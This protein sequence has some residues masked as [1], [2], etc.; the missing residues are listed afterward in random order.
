LSISVGGVTVLEPRRLDGNNTA[1]NAVIFNLGGEVVITMTANAQAN[2]SFIRSITLFSGE[3]VF[4]RSIL[5]AYTLESPPVQ[6]KN[7]F[8]SR[9][10]SFSL[11]G[12]GPAEP[13]SGG[14]GVP[15]AVADSQEQELI[16]ATTFGDTYEDIVQIGVA[17]S[18]QDGSST[19]CVS[20]DGVSIAD[21]HPLTDADEYH[22]FPVNNLIGDVVITIKST[23][24][25]THAFIKSVTLYDEIIIIGGPKSNYHTHTWRCNHAGTSEDRAYVAAAIDND[26]TILGFTD[27]LMQPWV[28]YET[29]TWGSFRF[30][31]DY[32]SSIRALQTEFDGEIDILL[33]FEAE[34]DVIFYP[35]FRWLL[36][37]NLVDYLILGQHEWLFDN[38]FDRYV[39]FPHQLNS[40]EFAEAFVDHSIQAMETGLFSIMAHPDY[41]LS[42]F[43]EWS[44]DLALIVRRLCEAALR[45]NVA[46]E[47][48]Q[49]TFNSSTQGVPGRRRV[50]PEFWDIAADVG[51]TV[52]IGIDAHAPSEF[53]E[54]H[55]SNVIDFAR[56]RGVRGRRLNIVEDL[57]IQRR[58]PNPDPPAFV[59][60]GREP[61]PMRTPLLLS[62]L[63]SSV[64]AQ[65]TTNTQ[66]DSLMVVSQ[67]APGSGGGVRF[68]NTAGSFPVSTHMFPAPV[69]V[70][71]NDFIHFDIDTHRAAANIMFLI[72]PPSGGSDLVAV[73]NPQIKSDGAL[74]VQTG[75][76]RPNAHMKG[77]FMVR[78]MSTG[79][80][81][82][83]SEG[84][85]TPNIPVSQHADAEGFITIRGLRVS[86]VNGSDPCLPCRM[87]RA[88]FCGLLGGTEADITNSYV[89]IKQLAFEA[90]T[91]DRG[92]V[93]VTGI[94]I[95]GPSS[96]SLM[97]D[98][99]R[100]DDTARQ[101]SAKIWPENASD[102]AYTWSVGQFWSFESPEKP[103]V[104]EVSPDGL[105]TAVSAGVAVIEARSADGNKAAAVTVFINRLDLQPRALQPRITFDVIGTGEFLTADYSFTDA[106]GVDEEDSMIQWQVLND[107]KFT[108]IPGAAGAALE[109]T[110]DLDLKTVRFL[111]TPRTADGRT[112][113]AMLSP[114]FGPL[115]FPCDCTP[116]CGDCL[117]PCHVNM[118][119]IFNI[120]RFN[121]NAWVSTPHTVGAASRVDVYNIRGEYG[122]VNIGGAH[123]NT[124]V[125]LDAPVPIP[126]ELWSLLTLHFDFT[127]TTAA[128]VA[129]LSGTGSANP[130]SSAV[131]R[132]L[133][134]L[135]LAPDNSNDITL[136]T[137]KG[138][139]GMEAVFA[140]MSSGTALA[141]FTGDVYSLLGMRVFAVNGDIIIREFRISGP[142]CECDGFCYDEPGCCILPYDCICVAAFTSARTGYVLN[143]RF[144]YRR[145]RVARLPLC[146][147][148]GR[149]KRSAKTQRGFG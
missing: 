39:Q 89:H 19:L 125:L 15:F 116:L 30:F 143:T 131:T 9:D 3:P 75:E 73:I 10:W 139:V 69:K 77:Y 124:S 32:K 41:F 106:S 6:G 48:N 26:F 79:S 28:N 20:I 2:D 58:T 85:F 23:E 64:I 7:T 140:N 61:N 97:A 117:C 109:L 72:A 128:T 76:I 129:L 14:R 98:S 59:I 84:V 90:C 60:P 147:R 142:P 127:V 83:G 136:G 51:N 88:L 67:V 43:R 74:D 47:I 35:Y 103:V 94:T 42:A 81:W 146:P 44:D 70:H 34:W 12:A 130:L 57:G 92:I 99:V 50:V 104:A 13:G 17:A 53:N 5:Y 33:G 122:F 54:T 134:P 95:D 22:L 86:A 24:P 93:P 16:V 100:P 148:A 102:T 101:L 115:R 49:V 138:T 111:I 56:A 18:C 25:G 1:Y 78:E 21:S 144:H 91:L 71:L 31:N 145:R 27:H 38:V 112:G 141:P 96:F 137:Y 149:V 8:L 105:V 40:L 133:A 52:V 135:N 87:R 119:G 108:D 113:R 11:P 66:S 114:P 126:R 65:Y 36:D 82:S 120:F 46:L 118:G 45:L 55:R 4:P 123:P 29:I 62:P 132:A 110:D 121:P 80:L 37:N 68:H 63:F 107:G